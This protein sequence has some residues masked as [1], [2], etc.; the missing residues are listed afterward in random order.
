MSRKLLVAQPKDETLH[1]ATAAGIRV[2]EC[3]LSLCIGRSCDRLSV[4]WLTLVFLGP[5]IL[6]SKI[7][8]WN[9]S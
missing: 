2:I 5:G 9:L 8:S 6:K 3:R 1:K 4:Q 7:M